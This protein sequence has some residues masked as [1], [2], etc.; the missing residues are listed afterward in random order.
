MLATLLHGLPERYAYYAGVGIFS[1]KSALSNRTMG[2]AS[3]HPPKRLFQ[4][5]S[6]SCIRCIQR[7]PYSFMSNSQL[8][9]TTQAKFRGAPVCLRFKPHLVKARHWGNCVLL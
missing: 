8:S 9:T 7:F 2:K 1:R 4:F 3:E 6:L 5:G